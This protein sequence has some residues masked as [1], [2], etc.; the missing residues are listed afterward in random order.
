M[1]SIADFT[2]GHESSLNDE[3][4][5]RDISI[6]N[7]MLIENEDDGFLSLTILPS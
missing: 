1:E 5:H 3:I 7:V 2:S 6:S 4:L